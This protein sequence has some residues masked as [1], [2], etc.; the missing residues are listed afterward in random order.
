VRELKTVKIHTP[1]H[2][3][4]TGIMLNRRIAGGVGNTLRSPFLLTRFTMLEVTCTSCDELVADND[5]PPGNSRPLLLLLSDA[6]SSNEVSS[7][8]LI[9]MLTSDSAAACAPDS[10]SVTA[11]TSSAAGGASESLVN[12]AAGFAG[13]LLKSWRS[14]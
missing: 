3:K 13:P 8:R 1:I 9:L 12:A 10:A 14:S 7:D 6:L 4:K 2:A 11:T 5:V